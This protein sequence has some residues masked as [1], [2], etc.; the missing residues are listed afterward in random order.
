[1]ID[2]G[3]KEVYFKDPNIGSNLP[4]YVNLVESVSIPAYSK[5]IANI[6]LENRYNSENKILVNLRSF[7]NKFGIYIG[8]GNIDS[9]KSWLTF[10][11]QIF[12]QSQ[13]LW[14]LISKLDK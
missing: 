9:S 5:I 14:M 11:S 2:T 13:Y 10:I 8:Q 6:N 12:L 1:M 4:E 7:N 3:Q